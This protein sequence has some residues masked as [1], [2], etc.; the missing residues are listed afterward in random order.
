MDKKNIA[1]L[2]PTLRRICLEHRALKALLKDNGPSWKADVL[3][4]QRQTTP[5]LAVDKQLHELSAFLQS[6]Q[7][8]ADGTQKLMGALAK[9]NLDEIDSLLEPPVDDWHA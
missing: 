6:G 8:D 5:E 4:F 3:Q 1:R 2:L 7:P 9:T